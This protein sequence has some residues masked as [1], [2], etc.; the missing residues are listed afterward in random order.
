M[1]KTKTNSDTTTTTNNNNNNI[2]YRS[3]NT[4]RLYNDVPSAMGFPY[5]TRLVAHTG[6]LFSLGFKNGRRPN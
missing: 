4:P 3:S 2:T 6:H 5:L 1:A